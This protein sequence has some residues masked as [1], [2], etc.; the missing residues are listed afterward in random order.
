[1]MK[2]GIMRER[3]SEPKG[4]P[5][6]PV[7]RVHAGKGTKRQLKGKK[8]CTREDQKDASG[9]SEVGNRLK[10][11]RVNLQVEINKNAKNGKKGEKKRLG[12]PYERTASQ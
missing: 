1:M 5:T 3:S 9:Y 6:S 4:L 11:S 2:R 10:R 12:S 8:S 7:S